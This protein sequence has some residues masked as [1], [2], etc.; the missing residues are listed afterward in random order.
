MINKDKW[1]NTL[2]NVKTKHDDELIQIDHNK[3]VN[4]I[5]KKNTFNSVKKYSFMTIILFLVYFLFLL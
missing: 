1:I 4:T 2:P 5:S 3:W